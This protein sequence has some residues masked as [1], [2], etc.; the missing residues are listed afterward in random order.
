MYVPARVR[1]AGI[2]ISQARLA[3]AESLLTHALLIHPRDAAATARLGQVLLAQGHP[4][5][6]L[7][8]IRE[9]ADF[10]PS[11][12]SLTRL[13]LV[14]LMT[15][16]LDS[17]TRA[18]KAAAALDTNGVDA[19]RY[20]AAVLV[21]QERGAEALPYIRQAVK[22]DPADGIGLG[23]LSLAYAQ[24]GDTSNAVRAA[25]LARTNAGRNFTVYVFAGRALQVVGYFGDAESFLNE[26]I[27]LNANDPEALTRLGITEVAL[28]RRAF[29]VRLFQRALAI[30]PGYPLAKAGLAELRVR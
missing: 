26:A 13:G 21:E 20:L 25:D 12:E 24:S 16:N 11:A 30:A 29:A 5:S 28:G 22:L 4:N 1:S 9:F 19:R 10:N 3:D 2:A 27:K 23:L 8:Y 18:L 7:P 6:A 14:Y 17:A 15:R